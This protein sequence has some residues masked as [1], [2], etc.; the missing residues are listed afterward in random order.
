MSQRLSLQIIAL[1]QLDRDRLNS[2]LG[3]CRVLIRAART[4]T[5]PAY[6]RADAREDS[7][8]NFHRPNLGP[9]GLARG[10]SEQLACSAIVTRT[11]E[12][13]IAGED[14]QRQRDKY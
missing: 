14:G 8:K 7:L 6:V 9:H 13:F 10:A 5:L 1:A 2:R 3:V 4:A 12:G 11:I